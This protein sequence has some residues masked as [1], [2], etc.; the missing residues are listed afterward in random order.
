[1]AQ[2]SKQ[3]WPDA[4]TAKYS[5]K[6]G[7]FPINVEFGVYNGTGINNP[8]WNKSVA[9][10]GRVEFG[11]VKEGFRA[12]ATQ[13]VSYQGVPVRGAQFVAESWPTWPL[14]PVG[15]RFTGAPF[16]GQPLLPTWAPQL[17]P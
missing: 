15:R 6:K 3:A 12:T 5:L 11:S 1:M 16:G 9:T 8:T 17:R 14:L 7:S 10:G 13:N 2:K 4:R